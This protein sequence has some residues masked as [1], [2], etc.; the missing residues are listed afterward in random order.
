MQI[1]PEQR[2]KAEEHIKVCVKETGASEEAVNKLKAGNFANHDEKTQCFAK[3]FME[4]AG[5]LDAEGKFQEDVIVEKLSKGNDQAKV[6]VSV[7]I[8]NFN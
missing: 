4:K 1:T 2:H 3:C 7:E 6:R 8:Y 5:F